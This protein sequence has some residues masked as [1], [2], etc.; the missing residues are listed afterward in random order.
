[1]APPGPG[2]NGPRLAPPPVVIPA[3]VPII[4]GHAP[5]VSIL[6]KKAF[7]DPDL[8]ARRAATLGVLYIDAGLHRDLGLLLAAWRSAPDDDASQLCDYA[9]EITRVAPN[10]PDARPAWRRALNAPD[11]PPQRPWL[12]SFFSR[13]SFPL[14]PDAIPAALARELADEFSGEL[15]AGEVLGRRRAARALARLA[16]LLD[17]R[18]VTVLLSALHDAD[19]E[20]RGSAFVALS[21]RVFGEL[22][23]QAPYAPARIL[24][25]LGR[26]LWPPPPGHLRS[27]LPLDAI[28]KAVPTWGEV[29]GWLN[30]ALYNANYTVRYFTVESP[31]IPS[32][33]LGPAEESDPPLRSFA[34]LTRIEQVKGDGSRYPSPQDRN[35]LDLLWPR[36][37]SEFWSRMTSKPVGRYRMILFIL[38]SRPDFP[39]YFGNPRTNGVEE[40]E[41]IAAF[42][43]HTPTDSRALVRSLPDSVRSK[44]FGH[45]KVWVVV[46]DYERIQGGKLKASVSDSSD[47]IQVLRSADLGGLVRTDDPN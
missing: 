23:A 30:Q 45:G 40:S 29:V 32:S 16:L 41:A 21:Y 39:S 33:G 12:A 11:R 8:E 35:E 9:K 14:R 25:P 38:E 44:P 1:M 6:L 28:A 5:E 34:I 36:S 10:S 31:H 24:L 22:A 7:A 42:W 20:V 4:A 13:T 2:S 47:L 26:P 43:W 18:Q 15:R 46:Y 19:P 3:D 27:R 37:F 17:D